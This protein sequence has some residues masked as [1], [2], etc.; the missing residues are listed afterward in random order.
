MNLYS[1]SNELAAILD[2][3]DGELT[4]DQSAALSELAMA[5]EQKVESCLQYR[6]GLLAEAKALGDEMDRLQE[7]AARLLSKADWLKRYILDSMLKT[8]VGK[9]STPT[10]T[11]S[12]AKSPWKT[13][14]AEGIDI[15]PEYQQVETVVKF[16]KAQ[17]LEDFKNGVELPPG[18]TVTQGFNLRVS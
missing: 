5:F 12:V 7:R 3:E 18:V 17:A 4:D 14:L 10:F 13:Q 1:I 11:A 15:P 8:N 6:E 2:S 16:N 9:V